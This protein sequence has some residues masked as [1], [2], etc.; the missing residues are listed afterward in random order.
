MKLGTPD[1]TFF[2]GRLAAGNVLQESVA[3]RAKKVGSG[4]RSNLVFSHFGGL[5]LFE[6]FF[7]LAHIQISAFLRV[8]RGY[9][10]R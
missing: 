9:V 3:K 2:E 10:I 4:A 8:Y 6:C 5:Y 7:L 1:P